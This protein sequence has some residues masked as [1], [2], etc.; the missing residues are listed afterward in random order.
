MFN[1]LKNLKMGRFCRNF[2]KNLKKSS[3]ENVK[4]KKELQ[5]IF[6]YI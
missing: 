6:L 4:I 1:M 5:A 3:H 2:F